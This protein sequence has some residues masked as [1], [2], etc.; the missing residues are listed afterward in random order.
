LI[1][2]VKLQNKI[3]YKKKG[4]LI[5]AAVNIILENFKLYY[6]N[7]A[8]DMIDYEY[9]GAF[10]ITV[11]TEKG[12]TYFY[13]DIGNTLRPLAPKDKITEEGYRLEFANRLQYIMNRKGVNQLALS[14][15]TGLTQPQISGYMNGRS[16]PSLQ[17]VRQ[18]A[19]ALKCTPE[20]FSYLSYV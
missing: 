3:L 13:N 6:N 15:L 14:E 8:R 20:E 16:L 2:V 19:M 9:D 7:I 17:K 12:S 11:T 18:I 5:M 10:G 4:Y 1:S